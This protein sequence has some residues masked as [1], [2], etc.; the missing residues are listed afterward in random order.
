[1]TTW[2]VIPLNDRRLVV[3]DEV[4]GLKDK[5]VIENMSS[6]RSSGVAQITKIDTQ[7]TSARTRLI[8]I[9]N[10]ADGTMIDERPGVG[11]DALRTV[12]KNQEDI[13]RFDFVLSARA[14]EVE[15]EVINQD[16]TEAPPHVHTQELS[17]ALVLWAWSLKPDQI[18]FTDNAVETA[19]KIAQQIGDEY[20]ADPPLLQTENARFKLYRIAAALAARTFHINWRAKDD[21]ELV[22]TGDHVLDAKRF[23][24]KIYDNPG[25][26]YRSV[27][28][29]ILTARKR[30]VEAFTSAKLYLEENIDTVF[31]TLKAVSQDSKFKGRDFEE[32]GGMTRDNALIAVSN[33]QKMGMI[34]RRSQGYIVMDKQL[35]RLLRDMEKDGF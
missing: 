2:G 31:A 17:S 23:L 4:S 29:R 20:V 16:F 8:W 11:I 35:V 26:E 28:R 22:V 30:A 12:V 19:R 18:R 32:F 3:L 1:M 6:I 21:M 15:P 25:M 9:T 10:P 34:H 33:L 27:S 14:S 5:D 13:A 7:E 24:D